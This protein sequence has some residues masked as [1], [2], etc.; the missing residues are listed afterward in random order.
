MSDT[1]MSHGYT[2]T[3]LRYLNKQFFLLKFHHGIRAESDP[4]TLAV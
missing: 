3:W 1:C 2:Y 4:M